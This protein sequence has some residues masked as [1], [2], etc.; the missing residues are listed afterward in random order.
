M[1]NAIQL[2]ED[3]SFFT[4]KEPAGHKIKKA[5]PTQISEK[6]ANWVTSVMTLIDNFAV[7][8]EIKW[9]ANNIAQK[10]N[11]NRLFQRERKARRNFAVAIFL[12][13]KFSK[14]HKLLDNFML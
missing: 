13:L 1:S 4:N 2:C 8:N 5:S 10:M 7:P 12:A 9:A 11:E 14:K 6:G 3:L